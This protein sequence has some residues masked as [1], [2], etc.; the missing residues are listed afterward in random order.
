MTRILTLSFA[1]LALTACG[2]PGPL[3]EEKLYR[4]GEPAALAWPS[5]TLDGGVLVER[6]RGSGAT[7]D[8]AMLY[9]EHEDGLELA[10][11][12]YHAWVDAPTALVQLQLRKALERAGIAD[13]TLGRD[14]AAARWRISGQLS[15]FHRQR[16]GGRWAADVE[17][18][19]RAESAEGKLPALVQRYTARV[20]AADVTVV[21]T[22]AA[23][24]Q[25]LDEVFSA[26]T[27]DFAAA[28][29]E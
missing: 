23:F 19:L 28:V 9:S 2:T 1:W 6:L 27:A 5:S 29:D 4:L 18:L 3:P 13:L 7:D 22:A 17:L 24:T 20:P 11:Y 15:R 21:A 14:A 26:F 16:V 12:A 25:A 10:S 8:R